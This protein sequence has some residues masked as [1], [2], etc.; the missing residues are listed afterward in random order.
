MKDR[1]N[2][3]KNQLVKRASSQKVL[4]PELFAGLIQNKRLDD[5]L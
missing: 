5:Q 3:Q 1:I 2:K 4:F